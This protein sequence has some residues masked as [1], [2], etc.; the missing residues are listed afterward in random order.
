MSIWAFIR[1]L[2]REQPVRFSLAVITLG[3]AGFFEGLGVAA[4][5]PLL[6]L[7]SGTSGTPDKLST[8]ISAGLKSIGLSFTLLT[9]L[10][11]ILV[12]VFLQQLFTLLQQ[13]I[14]WGSI[15]KFE[16]DQ[17]VGLYRAIFDSSW[18]FFVRSRLGDLV[19]ALTLEASRA[20]MAYNYL[21]QMLGALIV[22]V[23]Y[24]MLAFAL[25]W[26]MTTIVLVVGGGLAVA[27]RGRVA[28]G[29]KYGLRVTNLNGQL[30]GESIES[31]GGAKLVKGCAAEGTANARFDRISHHLAGEQFH[32]QMNTAWVRAFYDTISV[33][34]VIS[35]VYFAVTFFGLR[36]SELVV[37]LLIFYRVSPRLS[38]IQM[39]QHN[40]LAFLPALENID[41][42]RAIAADLHEEG[43]T[44]ALPPLAEAIRF[45]SVAFAYE[46]EKPVIQGIDLDVVCGK[47][48]AVVGPS[49]AGKTTIIDLVMRLILPDSG[50][51]TVDGVAMADLDLPDWRRRIGYVAQ[52][53][54]LFHTTIRDNIG[55]ANDNASEEQI[56]EAARLAYADEFIRELPE[57]YDTLV[58]D[59]GM[60][61]SGGQKQRVALAR[62]IARRPEILILDEATSALDAESEAKIQDAIAHLAESM[63]ILV[64]THRLA[65]VQDADYIYVLE[66]GRVV[67]KG[68]WDELVGLHGRFDELRKM[69]ALDTLVDAG[70]RGDS[71]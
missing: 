27:L 16:A 71:K 15:Y 12:L 25:S 56:H 38:N 1:R 51:A 60:R 46:P 57:G 54:V 32:M 61:L 18:P 37:F 70:E 64:V 52:D 66:A 2:L 24:L 67:E 33:S 58:G 43:G 40:V 39:L 19:N 47:M 55:W 62:A 50:E 30:Q 59:R 48:T 7:L 13:R 53:S 26:Q 31:I 69:Q 35:G 4:L 10:S 44:R 65:T 22:V 21:N 6:N 5:V 63:T 41:S 11:V 23:V 28:R 17:R 36:L 3:L 45:R 68:T 20:A 34:V 8:W 9:A 29:T 42:L 49:G 14:V